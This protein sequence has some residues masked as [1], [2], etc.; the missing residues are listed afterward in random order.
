VTP[1]EHCIFTSTKTF[2]EVKGLFIFHSKSIPYPLHLTYF[3]LASLD[4]FPPRECCSM[5]CILATCE[6]RKVR[7]WLGRNKSWNLWQQ[8]DLHQAS[9]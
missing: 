9:I 7:V 1:D 2:T 6:E 3:F 4:V 8:C 5:H